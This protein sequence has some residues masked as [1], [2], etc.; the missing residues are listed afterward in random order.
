MDSKILSE[1]INKWLELMDEGK[2]NEAQI[3][4]NESIFEKIIE[5]F[6]NKQASQA[7]QCNILFS[8]LG[9]T[10]EPIIL[11]QRL[12][13]PEVH[14][15]FTT[16]REAEIGQSLQ[17]SLNR[18]LTSRFQ[19]IYLRDESFDTIYSHLQEQMIIH[20]SVNYTIDITG[21]K[22]SMVASAAI[23]ARDNNCCVTYVDYDIYLEK[24]RRPLPGTE[25]LNIVYEVNS[26]IP[27]FMRSQ[28]PSSFQQNKTA[29][30]SKT[31]YNQEVVT[32][33]TSSNRNDFVAIESIPQT[34]KKKSG[35]TKKTAKKQPLI[36]SGKEVEKMVIKAIKKK[37]G[38][39]EKR[40]HDGICTY[41]ELNKILIIK[42]P[43]RIRQTTTSELVWHLKSRGGIIS[44]FFGRDEDSLKFDRILTTICELVVF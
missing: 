43:N 36:L 9:F 44:D 5:K 3:L 26:A 31:T 22:K 6:V 1:Q 28:L 30:S 2:T 14:I 38:D 19:I 8:I 40:I 35:S 4:Y 25:K 12:L 29:K 17:D 39:G 10:P 11:T 37:V 41:D 27:P 20:P 7:P 32:S 24:I 34:N 21:G 33:K 23:F 16:Q 18:Y 13:Q 15:I 42:R